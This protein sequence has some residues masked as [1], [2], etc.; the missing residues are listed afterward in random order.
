MTYRLLTEWMSECNRMYW[1]EP[2]ASVG[3]GIMPVY[4]LLCCRWHYPIPELWEAVNVR[5]WRVMNE[6]MKEAA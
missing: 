5:E 2:L 1:N 6:V 4:S 3:I